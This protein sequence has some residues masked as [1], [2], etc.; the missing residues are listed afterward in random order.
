MAQRS[1]LWWQGHQDILP[2]QDFTEKGQEP[3]SPHRDGETDW[4]T[5]TFNGESHHGPF[6][7]S[8]TLH[9]CQLGISKSTNVKDWGRTE[10]SIYS[11]GKEGDQP[12]AF[13][14]HP[15]LTGIGLSSSQHQ[16]LSSSMSRSHV[17]RIQRDTGGRRW[18]WLQQQLALPQAWLSRMFTSERTPEPSRRQ[19][20]LKCGGGS[21][22]QTFLIVL[23]MIIHT[24]LRGWNEK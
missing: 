2:S 23:F 9:P 6:S 4:G 3:W 8:K 14:E 5:G 12:S 20:R 22:T 7:S 17:T 1:L 13:Q 19:G 15:S 11:I 24:N 21:P 10:Y 18:T 16:Q